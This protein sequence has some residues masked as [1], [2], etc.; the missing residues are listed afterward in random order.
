MELMK[1]KLDLSSARGDNGISILLRHSVEYVKCYK[2]GLLVISESKF[3]A[4]Y[5]R[6]QLSGKR[7]ENAP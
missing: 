5:H 3:T 7:G 6:V 1:K 2:R 4:K